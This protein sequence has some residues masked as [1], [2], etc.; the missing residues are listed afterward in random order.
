MEA[1]L[2]RVQLKA[3]THTFC[4]ICVVLLVLTTLAAV[5]MSERWSE[6][7]D[8]LEHTAPTR[9]AELLWANVNE[10]QPPSS[11]GRDLYVRVIAIEGEVLLTAD[12]AR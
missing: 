7:G 9:Y 6:A 3:R 4:W 10:W 1:A 8:D 12:H 5:L 11:P 2:M